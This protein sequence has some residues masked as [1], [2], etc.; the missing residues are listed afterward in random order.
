M[1][2]D[3]A[4]VPAA[5]AA[6]AGQHYH[7]TGWRNQLSACLGPSTAAVF[8]NP[9]DVAKVQMQMQR[10]GAAGPQYRG[11]FD[12]LVQIA[13]AQGVSGV[14]RGLSMALIREGSKCTFRLG[15]YQPALDII[16]PRS[17]GRKASVLE[18]LGAAGFAGGVSSL[19]C[20]PVDIAKTRL[21]GNG[22]YVGV[23]DVFVRTSREEGWRALWKGTSISI[24]RSVLANCA[25]L[26]TKTMLS[27]IV[28]DYGLQ[29]QNHGGTFAQGMLISGV[30][31][32]IGGVAA[33][34]AMNPADVI[35]TR[36]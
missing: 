27:E 16:H 15:L 33:V 3:D 26:P 7:N 2:V 12:C 17:L 29:D 28:S 34:V 24:V 13:R 20:N 11:M 32:G 35:R 6:Q 30:T 18:R 1:S 8:T 14:Q 9:L 5:R 4:F 36:L 23:F 19:I 21:Q 22:G 31:G 10:K 25:S